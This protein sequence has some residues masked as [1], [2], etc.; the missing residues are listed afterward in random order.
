MKERGTASEVRDSEVLH[1]EA[2]PATQSPVK[3]VCD[4]LCSRHAD[5][6][7]LRLEELANC[8]EKVVEYD[9]AAP[10]PAPQRQPSCCQGWIEPTPSLS[11]H[12][13]IL[14]WPAASQSTLLPQA[15]VVPPL[16]RLRLIAPIVQSHGHHRLC[17]RVMTA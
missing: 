6:A 9:A 11:R 13:L 17:C 14:L 4:T 2:N 10:G 8:Q 1:A 3:G 12:H 15:R 16:F 7:Q 5:D